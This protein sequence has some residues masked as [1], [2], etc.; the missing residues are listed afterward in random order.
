MFWWRSGKAAARLLAVAA[1]VGFALPGGVTS[2]TA[3]ACAPA[4][5]DVGDVTRA[6]GTGA[7]TVFRFPVSVVVAA[8]C[9]ASGSVRFRTVDGA[10]ADRDPARAGSDYAATSGVLTWQGE[11][12]T[13][14]VTVA[15]AGDAVPELTEVFWVSL[16]LPTGVVVTG[17]SGAGWIT[18]DDAGGTGCDPNDAGC[19]GEVSTEGTGV[20]WRDVCSASAHFRDAT[21]D[22]RTVHVRTLDSGGTQL[23]YVP[24]KDLVLTVPPGARRA[25]VRFTITAAPGQQMRVP[26]EFFAPSSGSPGNLRTVLTLVTS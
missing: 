6:E 25:V 5:V 9:Q 10:S 14:Y 18:D 20:C 2:A 11:T 19:S 26:V 24:V 7:T 8:G 3:A 15:V 4:A 16:D 12:A 13:K 1:V 22:T 17:R 21:P 23:G